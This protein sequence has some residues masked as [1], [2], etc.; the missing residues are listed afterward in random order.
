MVTVPPS[1]VPSEVIV[2]ASSA[3]SQTPS[4][5]GHGP[6]SLQVREQAPLVASTT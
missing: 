5:G 1:V 4:G 2:A 6:P 3:G